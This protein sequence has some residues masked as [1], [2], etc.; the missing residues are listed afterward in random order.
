MPLGVLVAL[1]LTEFADRR[2]ARVI[3]LALDLLNGL[4]SIIIGVFVFG[5]LVVGHKQSGFAGLAWRWRS[6]CCR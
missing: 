6:S 3:R 1:F 4:P 2:S 5:L